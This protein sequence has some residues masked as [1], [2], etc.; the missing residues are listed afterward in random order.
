MKKRDQKD[1][2]QAPRTAL[3]KALVDL[4]SQKMLN[5]KGQRG[6]I[7]DISHLGIKF[8]SDKPYIKGSI[9]HLGLLLPN[10]IPIS[11]ITGKVVRCEQKDN[12]ECYTAVE[13]KGDYYLRSLIEAY[14]K[15]MK[16]WNSL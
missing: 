15:A 4:F 14:I 6:K 11:D 5:Q 1:R 3:N 2:R 12:V 16:S 13:Y 7:C 9:I 8:S 10:F